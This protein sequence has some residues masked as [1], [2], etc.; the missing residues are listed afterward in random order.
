[1]GHGG[2]GSD[3]MVRSRRA[4]ETVTFI[5]RKIALIPSGKNLL[6]NQRLLLLLLLL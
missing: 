5:S 3:D 4:F 1:M 2:V 6:T